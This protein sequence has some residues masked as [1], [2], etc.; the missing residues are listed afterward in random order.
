MKTEFFNFDYDKVY[1]SST[2]QPNLF[3]III[4]AG[5]GGIHAIIIISRSIIHRNKDS[6]EAIAKSIYMLYSRVYLPING[7]II[8]NAIMHFLDLIAS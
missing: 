5:T 6:G 4:V 7:I 8:G 3:L 2:G 1:L